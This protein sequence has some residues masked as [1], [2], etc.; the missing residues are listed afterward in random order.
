MRLLA[1]ISIL[2]LAA[3]CAL[4]PRSGGGAVRPSATEA[5]VQVSGSAMAGPTCPVVTEPPQSG[6]A[7]RP[8]NGAVILVLAADGSEMKRVVSGPDGRFAFV[9]PAG[10]YRLVPQRVA[11]LMGT[12]PEQTLDVRSGR[13]V[14]DLVITYDTG[15]R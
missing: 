14:S 3:G 10:R 12:A 8:V 5:G 9:L 15:I 13:G 1:G 2:L 4:F 11:G 6:C 7:A